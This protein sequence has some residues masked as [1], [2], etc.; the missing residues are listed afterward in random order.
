MIARG[1]FLY[2][3]STQ[4]IKIEKIITIKFVLQTTLLISMEF[5]LHIFYYINYNYKIVYYDY[6]VFY[7]FVHTILCV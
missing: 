2:N 4:C 5:F 7:V 3:T 6:N 1:G